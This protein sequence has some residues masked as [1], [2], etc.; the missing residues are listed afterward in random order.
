MKFKHLSA[1][2]LIAVIFI[3]SCTPYRTV[4]YFQN[5]KRDSVTATTEKITNY[6]PLTIQAGDLLALHVTSLNREADAEFN[7]NLERPNG[8]GIGVNLNTNSESV[9][10]GYLVDQHGEI[11]LPEAGKVKVSGNTTSEIASMLESRLAEY[12]SKPNVNIRILNF[13]ISVLGDVAKPGSFDIVNEKITVTQAL[14]L[15]GDLN[16]TGLRNN[17]LLIREIDGNREQITLNLTSKKIFNSPYYYL[18]NNDVIYV[19]P[20][21]DRVAQSDSGVIKIS[22]LISALSVLALFL[23]RF[24]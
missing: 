11:N 23:T 17:I 10:Y 7:Y 12:L 9:V 21:R 16:T 5:L 6:S 14:A 18:K 2:V 19:Q 24:N 1:I 20:N 15:A 3:S 8:L 13:R 4:P 22:L